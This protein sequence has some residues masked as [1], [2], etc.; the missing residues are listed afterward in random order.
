MRGFVAF[1]KKEFIEQLR[2]YK[3]L[4]MLCV[5]FLL[6]M[7]SPL[8]AKLTPEI[9]SEIGMNGIVL[10]LPDP[11]VADA[12][13]QFFKNFTSMGIIAVLLVFG[14]SLS[15]ELTRGTLVNIHAKGLPRRTV[16]LS[17]YAAAIILWTLS[18]LL[19]AVTNY[20]YSVYLFKNHSVQN[21]FLSFFCFWVFVCFAIALILL[22]S[23]IT[24]GSFGGLILSAGIL[25]LLLMI[26]IIPK[27]KEYNPVTLASVNVN[28]ITGEMGFDDVIKALVITIVLAIA[29]M[30]AAVKLYDKKKL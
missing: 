24:S 17:K 2:S 9:M 5:S 21:L 4:I 26:N 13:A 30:I 1:T 28:L 8:L 18:Y 3:I 14:G 23:T 20:G 16:I 22:S 15:N 25:I 10:K 12:Y 19:S 29:S 6:G 27:I 11:V 7:T